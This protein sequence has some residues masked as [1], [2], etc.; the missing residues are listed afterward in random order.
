MK[1][2]LAAIL[3]AFSATSVNS[4]AAPSREVNV[5]AES[6]QFSMPTISMDAI[7]LN[8]PTAS[9]FEGAPQF[10][11]DSWAQLEFFPMDRLAEVQRL[12]KNLKSFEAENRT[13]YGGRRFTDARLLA[14]Q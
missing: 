10:H 14:R 8:V 12:L 4:K 1:K 6:I 3:G 2:I 5:P 7:K 9:S 13:Q 11:E